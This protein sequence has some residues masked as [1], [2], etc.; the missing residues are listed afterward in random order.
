MR[1]G[2]RDLAS[3]TG[4]FIILTYSLES[5][6][7]RKYQGTCTSGSV[8][9]CPRGN[10]LDLPFSHALA[11]LRRLIITHLTQL[12]LNCRPVHWPSND[13]QRD[14][15]FAISITSQAR[16]Q[17]RRRPLRRFNIS[18]LDDRSKPHPEHQENTMP[19]RL[20]LSSYNPEFRMLSSTLLHHFQFQQMPCQ[21]ASRLC[22]RNVVST[23]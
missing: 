1:E 12:D 22:P 17:L 13:C 23:I 8:S 3:A 21:G 6:K 9:D 15:L 19:C 4:C 11:V 7:R 14:D 2:L 10:S 5:L 16:Y 18:V 20:F